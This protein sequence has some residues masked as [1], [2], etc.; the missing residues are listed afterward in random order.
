MP[1]HASAQL[2]LVSAVLAWGFAPDARAQ[3]AAADEISGIEEIV[4]SITKRA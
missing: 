4:V 1:Y 2:I 3:Q